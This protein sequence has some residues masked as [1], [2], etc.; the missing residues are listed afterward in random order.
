MYGTAVAP[1]PET[2]TLNGDL[3]NSI[4]KNITEFTNK[5]DTITKQFA[6]D[7]ANVGEAVKSSS[8]SQPQNGNADNT[9]NVKNTV[10]T[11]TA[12]DEKAIQDALSMQYFKNAIVAEFNANPNMNGTA[13]QTNN[14]KSGEGEAPFN[15]NQSNQGQPAQTNPPTPPAQTNQV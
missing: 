2:A 9:L 5:N 10:L 8:G 11:K 3:W 14:D 13:N 1:K 12:M 15:P 7:L 6:S 4:V